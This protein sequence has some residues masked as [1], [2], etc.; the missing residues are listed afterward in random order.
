[1]GTA[2]KPFVKERRGLM[3]WFGASVPLDSRRITGFVRDLSAIASEDYDTLR[4]PAN[5]SAF[6]ADLAQ[7]TLEYSGIYED[8]W[9]AE[10]SF[11][12]LRKPARPALLTVRAAVP[13]LGQRAATLQVLAD[14]KR[15]AQASLHAGDN[16]VHALL[17]GPAAR[18]RIDLRFD[19]STPLPAPDGRPVSAQLKFVGFRQSAGTRVEIADPLISLGNRWYPFESFDGQT[20]RWVEN[21]ARLEIAAPGPQPGE[22]AIDLE[23]GPGMG[24]KPVALRLVLPDRS[25]RVLPAVTGRQVLRIPLVLHGGVNPLALRVIGGGLA[26]A[27]DPR[28]LNF[29]VFA[30]TWTPD[31]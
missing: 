13:V 6:P 24:G 31:L 16:E 17:D 2:G 20:F 1:M 8:G 5:V 3:R 14:G 29:R 25:T 21:D 18:S 22:L 27:G 28:K 4:A 26:I 19:V 12:F 10:D 9:V 11:L 23:P 30:L 7:K 15:V